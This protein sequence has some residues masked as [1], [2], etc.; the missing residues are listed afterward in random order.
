MRYTFTMSRRGLWRVIGWMA[1]P[2]VRRTLARDI[3]GRVAGLKRGIEE[4]HLVA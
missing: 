3:R 1:E 2:I 4:L